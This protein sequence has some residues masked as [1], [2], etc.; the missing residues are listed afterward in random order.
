MSRSTNNTRNLK[1]LLLLAALMAAAAVQGCDSGITVLNA[2]PAVIA[3]GPITLDAGTAQITLWVRD[4]EEDAV[5]V[6]L[7]L[8]TSS[9]VVVLESLSGHG[10]AG[11]TT[12]RDDTGMQ[13]Y[14]EWTVAGVGETD[15]VTL[16]VT[17]TDRQGAAGETFETSAFTLQDGLPAP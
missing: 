14:I 9:G 17:P 8:V 2:G 15:S 11:L 4:Y 7:E 16:R 5:D 10:S 13:H 6:E 12:S 3:V 1:P